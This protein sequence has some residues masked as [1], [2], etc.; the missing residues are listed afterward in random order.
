MSP[1]QPPRH[2]YSGLRKRP[3]IQ[4]IS[5]RLLLQK[6]IGT[7]LP[8]RRG[9]GPLELVAEEGRGGNEVVQ[10]ANTAANAAT[11]PPANASANAA[12]NI[13]NNAA[14]V[15]DAQPDTTANPRQNLGDQPPSTSQPC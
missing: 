2:H 9:N 10:Q 11:N 1:S 5:R 14:N 6:Q 12:G 13:A 3:R 7:S 15:A 8:G 4:Q